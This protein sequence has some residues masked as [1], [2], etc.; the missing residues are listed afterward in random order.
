MA[1]DGIREEAV[2]DLSDLLAQATPD[3][4]DPASG[5]L[6]S[7]IVFRGIQRPDSRLLT[8][9]DRLGTD[10][11]PDLPYHSKIHLEEDLVRHFVR[12]AQG[13]LPKPVHSWW[14]AL[15]LA[16]HHGLP[17]R[18]LDWTR[19]PLVAAH[20]ATLGGLPGHDRVLWRLD[21]GEMQR[22]FGL[23]ERAYTVLDLDGPTNLTQEAVNALDMWSRLREAEETGRHFAFLLEPPAL[24]ARIVA[25]GGAFT[26]SSDPRR[27]LDELLLNEG[28]GHTLTRLVIPADHVDL[29]RDQLDLVN[30]TEGHLFPD[31]DGIA[32][33]IRRWYAATPGEAARAPNPRTPDLSGGSTGG[34]T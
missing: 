29:I 12:R 19:S 9:L 3:R 15:I 11:R 5:R 26:V 28:L 21:W 16:Q 13:L 31:L 25:Q 1:F 18:L 4:P 14:E 27:P 23:S 20:F 8:S 2:R 32:A 22:H 33:E 34:T 6:R 17:T 7:R 30:V 24:D 10:E